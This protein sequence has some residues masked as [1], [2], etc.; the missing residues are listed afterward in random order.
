LFNPDPRNRG[1]QRFCQPVLIYHTTWLDRDV[2][3]ISIDLVPF[4]FEAL[5]QRLP[6]SNSGPNLLASGLL[7]DIGELS[8]QGPPPICDDPYIVPRMLM[9][10]SRNSPVKSA[11]FS[12]GFERYK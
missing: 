6:L 10:L 5:H 4:G 2:Q 8:R 11:K 12:F 9:V 3:Q 7:G 1:R